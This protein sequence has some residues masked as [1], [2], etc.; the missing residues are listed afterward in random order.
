MYSRANLYVTICAPK[1]YV[2]K[3]THSLH[4]W[5][6]ILYTIALLV[7]ILLHIHFLS[8]VC[9]YVHVITCTHERICMSLFVHTR[10]A[11]MYVY[12]ITFT[13]SLRSCVECT[14][15]DPGLI[16]A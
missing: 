13:D 11:R 16:A 14:V 3:S 2:N 12:D 15:R 6:T 5:S 10:F 8:L 7:G 4:S 9:I 1:V